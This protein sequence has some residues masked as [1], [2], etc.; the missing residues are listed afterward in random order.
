MSLV[1]WGTLHVTTAMAGV[2]RYLD[3][4]VK[5]L[6]DAGHSTMELAGVVP[7]L[8]GVDAK[9]GGVAPPLESDALV[10]FSPMVSDMLGVGV[11][12]KAFP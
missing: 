5:T 2:A 11:E 10:V 4:Q 3:F 12:A 8:G 7:L 6:P 1:S 9:S